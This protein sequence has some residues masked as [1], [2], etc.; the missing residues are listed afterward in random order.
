[1]KER[2]TDLIS[3]KLIVLLG[4]LSF[5]TLNLVDPT[6]ATGLAW[7]I[8]A[9]LLG[10]WWNW[11][12]LQKL[13]ESGITRRQAQQIAVSGYLASFLLM[14]AAFGIGGYWGFNIFA[15]GSG[16]ALAKLAFAGEELLRKVF[17]R[18]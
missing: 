7:G 10:N 1:M 17:V 4:L 9:A 12:N 3:L 11:E 13:S 16:L 15:I 5:V 2:F 8:L 18:V 6:S 14:L